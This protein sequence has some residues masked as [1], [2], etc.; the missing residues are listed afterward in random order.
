MCYSVC[1]TACVLCVTD[2]VAVVVDVHMEV[3]VHG[4]EGGS[5]SELLGGQ[6]TVHHVVVKSIQQL[7]VHIAY[8]SIQDLLQHNKNN[9]I[10]TG[11]CLFSTCGSRTVCVCVCVC[12]LTVGRAAQASLLGAKKVKL[13]GPSISSL[14]LARSEYIWV[15]EAPTTP[16][17]L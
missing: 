16:R 1:A 17:V 13:P 8:Q 4:G 6:S 11:V 10:N 2:P 7:D 3:L 12:V 5:V 9:N 14:S 15:V